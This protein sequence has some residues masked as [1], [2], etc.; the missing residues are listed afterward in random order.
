MIYYGKLWY[1]ENNDGT[2]TMDKTMVL[3][4]E[5]H[6]WNFDLR[7]KK[8]GRLPKTKK[9]W[10]IMERTMVM[11]SLKKSIALELWFTMEKLWKK[12]MMLYR[13]ECDFDLLW[14]K[15]CY[16]GQNYGTVVNYSLL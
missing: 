8:R 5:L 1:Y 2:C 3:Y 12:T 7:R 4:Q 9:V 14:R 13:K 6:V 15:L 11:K 16:Y 10:F